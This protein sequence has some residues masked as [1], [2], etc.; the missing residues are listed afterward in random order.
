M[1]D[2]PLTAKQEAFVREYLVDFNAAGAA[3]RAGY[4]PK[5]ANSWGSRLLS[6]TQHIIDAKKKVL[7]EKKE[8]KAEHVLQEFIRLGFSNMDDYVSW[9]EEGKVTVKPSADLSRGKK[10]AIRKIESE[11][12]TT[13]DE[14]GRSETKT[15]FKFELHPKEGPLTRL[16]EKYG[17]FPKG[18][19]ITNL[20]MNFHKSNDPPEIRAMLDNMTLEDKQQLLALI[21]K[22]KGVKIVGEGKGEG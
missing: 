9:D 5:Q 17:L 1:A 7:V 11:T 22:A 13:V 12:T 4:S 21:R 20:T 19:E 3:V 18:G 2:R 6:K 8:L 16:G 10:S 15:K 14:E